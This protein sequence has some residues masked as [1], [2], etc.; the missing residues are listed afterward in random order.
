VGRS[1]QPNTQ[2]ETALREVFTRVLRTPRIGLDTNFF[3]LGATSLQLMEAHEA[4]QRAYGDLEIVALF[5]NPNIRSLASFLGR[6]QGM[7]A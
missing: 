1:S 7:P 4:L 3:D 2:F 6:R 5:E